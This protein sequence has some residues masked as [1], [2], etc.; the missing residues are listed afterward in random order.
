L[1]NTGISELPGIILD[2]MDHLS[3]LYLDGNNF[4][5]VPE[6]LVAVAGSLKYLHLSGNPIE[7]MDN[8]SFNGLSKLEQLNISSLTQLTE[9]TKDTFKIV[10]SLEVLH[11]FG[12]KNLKDFNMEDLKDLKHLRELDLS[13]NALITLDFGIKEEEGSGDKAPESHK[14]PRAEFRKLRSLRLEG[15][16]WKCDCEMMLGLSVFDHKAK[17]FIKSTNN[18]DARCKTPYELSGKLLYE[19]PIDY[20][21]AS[22]SNQKAKIPIYDPPAFLRPKSI[23]LTVFSV[24]GVVI[25]GIFI[26]FAIV[27]IKRRLKASDVGYAST[28]I[29][30]TTVRESTIS[31][32]ANSPYSP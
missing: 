3:E 21:C 20:T 7:S 12:N 11:C 2:K 15:N 19:L 6:S 13:H 31:N 9:I 18:D 25:L 4:L 27:C 29:R 24:V 32:V 10:Q 30:Y 5:S 17:Y 8:E 1:S 28:P 14:T 26:G 22:H 16:P 23:M